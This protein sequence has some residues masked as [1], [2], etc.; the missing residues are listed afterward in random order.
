LFGRSKVAREEWL[1]Q[2]A[3]HSVL[4]HFL[5]T[6]T[7]SFHSTDVIESRPILSAAATLDIAPGVKAQD[8]HR[9]DFIWHQVHKGQD[10]YTVGRDL[11]MGLLVAGVDTTFENGATLFVP[12]SHLWDHERT[13][14]PEEVKAAALKVGQAFLF[15]ASTAHAGGTNMTNNSRTVHGF[16][17]CRS[18]IRPEENQHLWW[19]K[20]EVQKWS[21]QAQRQAG[22]ILDLPFVG[23]CDEKN[24]IDLFRA[25]DHLS[26]IG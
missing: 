23:H 18:Y 24:P 10:V 26:I 21:L 5:L 1:Q 13:P 12:G 3:L 6:R 19:T 25:C 20:E 11:G 22:Y 14:K 8:I 15:L 16:F 7:I 4:N 17:F 9:D 2:P